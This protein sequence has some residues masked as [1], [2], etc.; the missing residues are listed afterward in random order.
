MQKR[1]RVIIYGAVLTI[2]IIFTGLLIISSN[3]QAEDS[4]GFEPWPTYMKDHQK[5]GYTTEL[6]NEDNTTVWK[7]NAE[8]I[9][10]SCP[11]IVDGVVYFGTYQTSTLYALDYYNG[12][13][14]WTSQFPQVFLWQGVTVDTENNQLYL[15]NDMYYAVDLDTG[16]INWFFDT[17][18]SD[19]I[20]IN[21]PIYDNGSVY[22]GSL[23]GKVYK[24]PAVD[25]NE[26]GE[27]S[28]DEIE[29]E[30][31]TGNYIGDSQQD[32][33]EGWVF[34]SPTV[35]DE[36]VFFATANE[37]GDDGG[38]YR[39]KMYCLD[40]S[41][42][43][44]IWVYNFGQYSIPYTGDHSGSSAS[45]NPDAGDNGLVFIGNA[46]TL[47]AFDMEGETNGDSGT[48]AD[49]FEEGD[50]VWSFQSGDGYIYSTAALNNGRV[51][52]TTEDN[53]IYAL[54]EEN[55]DE[56]WSFATE[57]R[58]FGSAVVS[59]GKVIFGSRDTQVYVLD[60]E[61]GN[62]IWNYTTGHQ[63]YSTPGIYDERIYI[64][65]LDGYL[66]VFSFPK[67]IPT[68]NP[69]ITDDDIFISKDHNANGPVTLFASVS[70]TGEKS[71]WNVVVEFYIDSIST[72]NLLGKSLIN[73][74]RPF[75]GIST[76]IFEWI[77]ENSGDY[78][79]ITK[80]QDYPDETNFLDNKA[81][82]TFTINSGNAKPFAEIQEISPFHAVIGKDDVN[83]KGKGLDDGSISE[84][85][86]YSSIDGFL[87]A[88]KDFSI[89]AS[90]LTKG[91]HIIYLK[92]KDNTGLWSKQVTKALLIEMDYDDDWLMYGKDLERTGYSTSTLDLPTEI[93][94]T[95]IFETGFW[96]LSSPVIVDG[97]VYIASYDSNLY[98]IDYFSGE[99]IWNMTLGDVA[100]STPAIDIDNKRLYIC[101]DLLYGIDTDNG[102]VDW[103]FQTQS[104]YNWE[105]N[106]PVFHDNKVFI[107]SLDGNMY[108]VNSFTGDE[109]WHFTTGTYVG[110]TREDDSEGWIYG[111]PTVVDGK[112]FFSTANEGG[113]EGAAYVSKMYALDEAT[114]DVIW[115]YN[116]GNGAIPYTGDHSGSGPS[117]DMSIGDNGL[118]FVGNAATVYAFDVEG[119]TDGDSIFDTDFFEEGELV[120]DYETTND[121]SYIYCSGSHYDGK[122]FFTCDDG[123]VYA[124]DETNGN[125]IW[126]F[127]SG[128]Y[129]IGSVAIADERLYF[130][131][132]DRFVYCLDLD[133]NEIW[134]YQT[135]L[136]ILCTPAVYNDGLII[137][138]ADYKLYSFSLYKYESDLALDE[139]LVLINPTE[140]TA[141]EDVM[142]TAGIR[143]IGFKETLATVNFYV[144]DYLIN[145]LRV[146][147]SPQNNVGATFIWDTTSFENPETLK[148][149]VIAWADETNLENNQ[150]EIDFSSISEEL[151]V[152]EIII[153]SIFP[154]QALQSESVSLS[155]K[156]SLVKGRNIVK[157]YWNS[158]IDGTI[159]E[160]NDSNFNITINASEL[161]IGVH[162]ISL[163]V[164]DSVG[165]WSNIASSELTIFSEKPT[166]V[167]TVNINLVAVND[168][169]T[170]EGE[171]STSEIEIIEYFF[172]FGDG[173]DSG[174]QTSSTATHKYTTHGIFTANLKVKDSSDQISENTAEITITVTKTG[175]ENQKPTVSITSPENDDSYK[176]SDENI[177]II[178]SATDDNEVT[179]VEI[180]ID[181]GS[182]ISAIGTDSWTYSLQLKD[183]TAGEHIIY[184]RA[185]DGQYYSE[186]SQVKIEIDSGSKSKD[187]EIEME[188]IA[189]PAI[190]L[191]AIGI[192]AF[193]LLKR[194]SKE[195]MPSERC[196]SCRNKM[197][198]IDDYDD[199][200]C[201]ECEEYLEEM[202]QNEYTM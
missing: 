148:I 73:R 109:V 98:A 202:N 166:S 110:D 58:I 119:Q 11:S 128:G 184:A 196:P 156:A 93:E 145:E 122:V 126:S 154:E 199:H 102:Q 201:Y 187:D 10:A 71:A 19:D 104:P 69:T 99:L 159:A 171:D 12:E 1:K 135:G 121:G 25:P 167:L 173:D 133:G 152:P 6:I 47:Y 114:G 198:Y 80:I 175:E 115:V 91:I 87:S 127:P 192:F 143:N 155:L 94:P 181:S 157:Y 83:F 74:V 103:T 76:A 131:S 31:L 59:D 132:G 169:V 75:N 97:V 144:D 112:V 137:P 179:L 79:I 188:I 170:F 158:S 92:V 118:V 138:S 164:L 160:G 189:I 101:A 40:A 27:I 96:I 81:Q 56:V 180:R 153:N 21:T 193:V 200:Y 51:Y 70:N 26:D 72:G 85:E 120:W 16:E 178:G 17:E 29:W 8:A 49:N 168:Q 185:Y 123:Y 20:E 61:S 149:E 117:V 48:D 4:M 141:G 30:F 41:D 142:I 2:F 194:K 63:I 3:S 23:N 28:M 77:P 53:S 33:S 13:E 186:I 165:Q 5:T 113:N 89:P 86:W 139:N 46:D 183:L 7:Y 190:I 15:S 90:D 67:N 106:S 147:V 37:G 65:S 45:V 105:I 95:W 36:K 57:S 130:G 60:E 9:V 172:E 88:N 66:Y 150:I 108:A 18:F 54:N 174:W 191:V 34:G 140:F 44:A 24:V 182:W 125:L 111:S 129:I 68:V 116:F 162:T 62:Q 136:D 55:G 195:T 146:R 151:P 197:E 82:K 100:F 22:F 42:G 43:S 163:V 78:N 39:S 124:L 38:A 14:I 84:Y 32:N 176:L 52:I 35:Y 177:E 64:G 50:V 161:S 134:K 107:G